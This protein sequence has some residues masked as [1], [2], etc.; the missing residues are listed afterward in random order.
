MSSEERPELLEFPCKFPIKA[1]GRRNDEFAQM[2]TDLV[3]KHADLWEPDAV[4]LNSSAAG[5][6][7]AVTVTI[8]ATSREQLD[9]I[10][11]DLTACDQIL[12]AL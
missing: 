10:Y 3:L 6:F 11:M 5:R 8:K 4:K 1:M 7:I 2:V 9:K 12:M